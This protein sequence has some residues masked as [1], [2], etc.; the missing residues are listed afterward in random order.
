MKTEDLDRLRETLRRGDPA[1]DGRA[2]DAAET[3]LLRARLLES[4]AGAGHGREP[5]AARRRPVLPTRPRALRP[6]F[7]TAAAAAGLLVLTLGLAVT[8]WLDRRADRAV[9]RAL[10]PERPAEAS[11]GSALGTE[12]ETPPRQIQFTTPGGTRIVWVL[13]PEQ[14]VHP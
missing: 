4:A 5:A 14:P 8:L 1:A 12:A 10:G 7:A 6:S 11:G 2:P 3:A 9:D 13:Y